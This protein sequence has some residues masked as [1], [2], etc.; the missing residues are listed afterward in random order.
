MYPPKFSICNHN[1]WV[2]GGVKDKYLFRECTE[3]IN[4]LAGALLG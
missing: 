3:V 4:M 1:G 2:M